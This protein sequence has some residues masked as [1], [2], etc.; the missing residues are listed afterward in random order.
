MH[1]KGGISFFAAEVGFSCDNVV[2]YVVV[3]AD[4]KLVSADA[5]TNRALWIALKGGSNNFGVVVRIDMT[6]FSKL[7]YLGG[8]ITAP[9]T[10]VEAQ[11]DALV[12][13]TEA[14]IFDPFVS[15]ILSIVWVPGYGF[16]ILS[17]LAHT[18]GNASLREPPP[19][20]EAFLSIQPQIANTM[21][22]SNVSDFV[23]EYTNSASPLNGLR[24]SFTTTTFRPNFKLI[25]EII[26]FFNVT[27]SGLAVNSSIVTAALSFEP[28]PTAVTTKNNGT[29]SL[30]LGAEDG[31][32]IL[33]QINFSW[34]SVADDA[35]V[36]EGSRKLVEQI[37]RTAKL[38]GLFNEWKYLNYAA[39]FQQVFKGY[40]SGNVAGLNRVSK[41][42]DPRRVFQK[43]IPG[44]FKLI[45]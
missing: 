3:L 45:K 7:N 35:R 12:N 10:T 38:S 5:V 23:T 29:N 37:D 43:D 39:S 9:F 32:L 30:G 15:V 31:N 34:T 22:V 13:I 26:T 17:N 28:L 27:L 42:Y 11:I 24:N 14:K 6:T 16:I 1:Q 19:S 33:L 20:I 21:R 18:S 2:K 25:T 41:E 44:G 40:G 4:G 36:N 8:A